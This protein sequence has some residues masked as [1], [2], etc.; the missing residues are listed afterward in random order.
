MFSFVPVAEPVQDFLV[1]AGISL[2][3]APMPEPD[4]QLARRW[5][6]VCDEI[7]RNQAHLECSLPLDSAKQ[8]PSKVLGRVR[9]HGVAQDATVPAPLLRREEVKPTA[10]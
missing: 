8:H 4:P 3:F 10:A 6:V 7:G 9:C 5:P 1:D 2:R